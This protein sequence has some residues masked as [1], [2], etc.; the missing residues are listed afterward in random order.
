MNHLI[1]DKDPCALLYF[2]SLISNI[3]PHGTFCSYSSTPA[4]KTKAETD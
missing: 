3:V 2:L 1:S 4:K